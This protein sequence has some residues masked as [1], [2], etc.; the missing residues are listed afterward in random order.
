MSEALVS[1]CLPSIRRRCA[2]G[3]SDVGGPRMFRWRQTF[4]SK[5]AI[6]VATTT[7]SEGSSDFTP[8][9]KKVTDEG[10]SNFPVKYTTSSG[11]TRSRNTTSSK[12]GVID[13]PFSFSDTF[14]PNFIRQDQ[15]GD[16]SKPKSDKAN[17]ELSSPSTVA[18]TAGSPEATL[19]NT[20][21]TAYTA[22][23]YSTVPCVTKRNSF[24]EFSSEYVT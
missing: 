24:D 19:V 8:R 6:F 16:F 20:R 18:K 21:T 17:G 22:L 15:T 10:A 13:I 2:D 23:L 5:A 12:N 11:A 7:S 14:K 1:G 3:S 9:G 4:V